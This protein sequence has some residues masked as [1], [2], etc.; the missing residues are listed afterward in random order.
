MVKVQLANEVQPIRKKCLRRSIRHERLDS[1]KSLRRMARVK[2]YKYNI[3][4]NEPSDISLKLA[5]ICVAR[6][7][8]H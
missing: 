4:L 3:S 1:L 7:Q 2:K 8:S 5:E 6:F